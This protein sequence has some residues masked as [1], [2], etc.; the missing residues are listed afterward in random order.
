MALDDDGETVVE[1]VDRENGEGEGRTEG[2]RLD[3]LKGFVQ[4]EGRHRKEQLTGNC[5]VTD[6]GLAE[7]I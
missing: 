2:P 3:L 5:G 6:A 4:L 7:T 1:N